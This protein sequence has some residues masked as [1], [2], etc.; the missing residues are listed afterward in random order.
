M[1]P[2]RFVQRMAVLGA[3]V[4]APA[5]TGQPGGAEPPA[6]Q[7][8]SP[9]LDRAG[10]APG[11]LERA[12]QEG[13]ALGRP[14]GLLGRRGGGGV[15]GSPDGAGT[16]DPRVGEIARV[17]W[18]LGAVVALLLLLRVMLRRMGGPLTGGRRPS[19]VLEV[20]ARFPV[21]R[22]QQLVLL[23]LCGRV[24]LLHQ[25]RTGMT[26]LSE[27]SDPDEVAALLAR[28]ESAGGVSGAGGFSTL[29]DRIL[30]RGRGAADDE[31]ARLIGP[32][33]QIDG[34]EVVDLTRR[35]R[36]RKLAQGGVR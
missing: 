11:A 13:R 35:P 16:L 2:F 8:T 15:D 23:K 9:D 20:L 12:P 33:K 24:V 6:P 21:A 22:A 26:T 14:A 19:G 36:R 29:L 34:K 17:G 32:T 10:P 28:V 31:F 5:A 7:H 3:I 4:I 18:A 30:A 1:S 27:V 25:T